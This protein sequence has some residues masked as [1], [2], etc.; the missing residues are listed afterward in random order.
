M[1]DELKMEPPA[2]LVDAIAAILRRVGPV[3]GGGYREQARAVIALFAE[4]E[5]AAAELLRAAYAVSHAFLYRNTPN[6]DFLYASLAKAID[7]AKAA[8]IGGAS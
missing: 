1:T 4:R 2:D 8:G 6:I 7:D 3:R 5:R